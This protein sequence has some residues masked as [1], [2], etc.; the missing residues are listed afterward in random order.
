MSLC[1][2]N[3]LGSSRF[4]ALMA[5]TP[6]SR[7]RFFKEACTAGGAKS[8][9]DKVAAISNSIIIFDFSRNRH[10]VSGNKKSSSE[11]A[12]GLAL[13]ISTVA[14]AAYYRL[15]RTFIAN[16][17]THTSAWPIPLQQNFAIAKPRV[18]SSSSL[19]KGSRQP[20]IDACFASRWR[21]YSATLGNSAPNVLRKDQIRR[22]SE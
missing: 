22:Y 8:A 6:A 18:T 1:G 10:R 20:A 16:C 19:V 21:T 11:S 4:P 17:V 5:I 13:A 12:T 15:G 14:K 7:F 2:R 9:A 3:Q